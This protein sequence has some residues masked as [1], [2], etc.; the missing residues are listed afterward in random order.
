MNVYIGA[1][2]SFN[3]KIWKAYMGNFH[4]AQVG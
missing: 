4:A 1:H 2:L 3:F